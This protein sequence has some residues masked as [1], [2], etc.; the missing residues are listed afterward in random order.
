VAWRETLIPFLLLPLPILVPSLT[1][2]SRAALFSAALAAG[3]ALHP[4]STSRNA[5]PDPTRARSERSAF[6]L[7]ITGANGEIKGK[8]GQNQAAYAK[9]PLLAIPRPT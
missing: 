6:A 4:R 9:T 8:C 7:L 5:D 2:L 1:I 3:R